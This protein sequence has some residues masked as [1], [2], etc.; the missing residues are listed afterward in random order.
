MK[1]KLG[2][3]TDKGEITGIYLK[4]INAQVKNIYRVNSEFI[5]ESDL[6]VLS[7]NTDLPKSKFEIND[8]T[9]LG[10]VI[11]IEIEDGEYFYEVLESG[12]LIDFFEEDTLWYSED[13]FQD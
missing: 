13:L 10:K 9:F 8:V 2:Q 11:G 5:E 6:K 7:T 1:Y 3:K 12:E 4:N